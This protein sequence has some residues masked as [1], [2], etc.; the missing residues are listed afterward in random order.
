MLNIADDRWNSILHPPKFICIL[1]IIV[2]HIL[3][4]PLPNKHINSV[5]QYD[6][7]LSGA[8]AN[9]MQ[10]SSH[11][12]PVLASSFRRSQTQTHGIELIHSAG[13]K[14]VYS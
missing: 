9:I 2:V 12:H 3:P 8:E 11:T 13:A 1:Y 7:K 10:S 14:S 5:L 6:S 4:T